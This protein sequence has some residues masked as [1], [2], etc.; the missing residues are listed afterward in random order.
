MLSSLSWFRCLPLRRGAAEPVK[1]R[2]R[3]DDVRLIRQAIDQ[4]LAQPRLRDDLR[5]LGQRQV[6]YHDHRR[7]L[8]PFG[9]HLGH[10]LARDLGGRNVS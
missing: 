5:P 1:V 3:C 7:F 9:D 8:R 4:R 2:A 10:Q 6:G